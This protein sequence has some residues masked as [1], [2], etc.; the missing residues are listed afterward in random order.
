ME[1]PTNL[2]TTD[3]RAVRVLALGAVVLANRPGPS[4]PCLVASLAAGRAGP[5]H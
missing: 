1:P 2:R 4:G 5:L 3:G